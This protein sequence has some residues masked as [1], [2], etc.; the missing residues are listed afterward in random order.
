MHGCNRERNLDNNR[1]IS[2]YQNTR[3]Y[4][5]AICQNLAT[6]DYIPQPILDVSPPKWHLAHTSWFFEEFILK[7]YLSNYKPFHEKY[8]FLFNSYYHT[9]G[10]FSNRAQRGFL[11]RPTVNEIFQ[12][13]QCVDDAMQT[14][15]NKSDLSLNIIKLVEL[16]LNHEQQHQELLISDIKYI[17]GNNPLYPTLDLSLLN[18]N[19][20][21][22][23]YIT[24]A[25]GNYTIG[26]AGNSFC[27]DNELVQHTVYLPEFSINSALISN[28]EYIQF[29]EDSGYQRFEL[30]HDEGWHYLKQHNIS[31]PLY[32]HKKNNIWH[33]YNFNGL[34][35]LILT[36]AVCHINYYEAA[37][38]AEWCKQR[39]PTEFEWEI[40]ADQFN[41]G[42]RW[43]WTGSAYLPYPGFTKP[44]GAIGEYNGKF[45]I[46]Q[47]V[48]RGAS[49][50]TSPNH[51][52]K[53]YRNFFYPQ[54]R[55]Q[56]TGIR[57]VK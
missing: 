18:D 36:D 48:L 7:P 20:D 50:A 24:M 52:R 19:N 42:T 29:I 17:L 2:R 14:L 22:Q 53:T 27:F 21:K 49:I 32:W 57:L 8:S 38:F 12:Y 45:M 26:H 25:S 46:N 16:G 51:S 44:A 1:L 37:A 30:W 39:L 34:Q 31:A 3:A 55:W 33:V 9:V 23:E 35:P 40:A 56:F 4:T 54:A 6:E 10:Q 47:M 41:W 43:E 15:L 28:A 11:T 13:R 5:Q